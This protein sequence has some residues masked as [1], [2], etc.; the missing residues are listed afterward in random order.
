MAFWN[1]PSQEAAERYQSLVT[2]RAMSS[3][4]MKHKVSFI[5]AGHGADNRPTCRSSCDSYEPL[6]SLRMYSSIC[7]GKF[8]IETSEMHA[9]NL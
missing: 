6:A 4:L 3:S 9:M 5:V 2:R 8:L 7:R 1:A